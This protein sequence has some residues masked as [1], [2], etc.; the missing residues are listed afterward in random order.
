MEAT[1]TMNSVLLQHEQTEIMKATFF[2][3]IISA[4]IYVV[5]ARYWE[6]FNSIKQDKG[7]LL[8]S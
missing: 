2:T 6:G 4:F 5:N 3:N 7:G 8:R 1:E